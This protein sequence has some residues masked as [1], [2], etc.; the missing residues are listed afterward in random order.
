M[1][2]TSKE[3]SKA[4]NE[5]KKLLNNCLT[6]FDKMHGGI[7]GAGGFFKGIPGGVRIPEG[8]AAEVSG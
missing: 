7:L 2:K 1:V 4:T 5:K 6:E 3:F 8:I